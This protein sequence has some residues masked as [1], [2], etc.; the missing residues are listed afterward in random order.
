MFVYEPSL[1]MIGD[2]YTSLTSFISAA[3][4]VMCFAAALQGYFFGGNARAWQRV[5]LLVAAVLLIKPGYITDAIG[6]AI[7]VT[8]FVSNRLARSAA[9]E[10]AKPEA[11]P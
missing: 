7:L 2:W 1:L 8:V 4:G 11:R 6:V 10:D 9:V 5:A 3:I